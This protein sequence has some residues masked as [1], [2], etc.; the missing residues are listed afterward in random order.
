MDGR[1]SLFHIDA[2]HLCLGTVVM[3][4][5]A[6]VVYALATHYLDLD[7]LYMDCGVYVN[8]EYY[9]LAYIVVRVGSFIPSGLWIQLQPTLIQQRGDP[10]QKL[11]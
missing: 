5:A 4:A 11:Q 3:N 6:E 7:T 1:R 10:R 8:N 9:P 2:K